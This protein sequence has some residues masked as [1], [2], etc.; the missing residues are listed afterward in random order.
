MSEEISASNKSFLEWNDKDFS[1]HLD[2]YQEVWQE[3]LEKD[4]LIAKALHLVSMTNFY[5]VTDVSKRVLRRNN[6]MRTELREFIDEVAQDVVGAEHERL[7]KNINRILDRHSRDIQ[8]IFD[9][10]DESDE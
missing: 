5:V 9:H 6:E 2:E 7:E 3:L 1:K 10:L 8:R 4:P